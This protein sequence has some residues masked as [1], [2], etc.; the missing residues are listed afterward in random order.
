M[1]NIHLLTFQSHLNTPPQ[2]TN[3]ALNTHELCQL[4]VKELLFHQHSFRGSK[5]KCSRTATLL[6]VVHREVKPLYSFVTHSLHRGR[7]LRRRQQRASVR[8][9]VIKFNLNGTQI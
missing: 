1:H 5:E 7:L 6:Y 4:L 8:W 3:D 2:Y 9:L